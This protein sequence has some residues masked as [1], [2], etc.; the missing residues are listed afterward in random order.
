MSDMD[1]LAPVFTNAA[2]LE[3]M[4]AASQLKVGNNLA[5][6]VNEDGSTTIDTVIT[7][8][9]SKRIFAVANCSL[10]ATVV[11]QALDTYIKVKNSL[12]GTG[13]LTLTAVNNATMDGVEVIVNNK[14]DFPVTINDS[15]SGTF[16]G[17]VNYTLAAGKSARFILVCGATANNPKLDYQLL[18]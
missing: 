2:P 1:V 9:G 7:S 16:E 10:R 14:S 3:G 11:L 18:P 4:T 6:T 13:L 15:N 17:Q 12:G 8:P 5:F